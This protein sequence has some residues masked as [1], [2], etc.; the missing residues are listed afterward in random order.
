MIAVLQHQ[1]RFALFQPY[2][3]A[4]LKSL[5]PT[6]YEAV[7]KDTEAQTNAFASCK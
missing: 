4:T 7:K 2:W 1:K 5:L 6:A 3:T